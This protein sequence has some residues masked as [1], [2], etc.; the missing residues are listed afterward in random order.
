MPMAS[1]PA[2]GHTMEL[3]VQRRPQFRDQIGSGYRNICIRLRPNPWRP[4]TILLRKFLSSGIVR[5]KRLALV[6]RQQSLQDGTACASRSPVACPQSMASTRAA[7]AAG[8]ANCI[9]RA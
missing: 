3:R 4:M 9:L 2:I 6:G 7:I 1:S 5:G 8:G